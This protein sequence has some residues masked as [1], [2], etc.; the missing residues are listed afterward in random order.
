MKIIL[1]SLATLALTACGLSAHAGVVDLYGQPGNFY[2]DTFGSGGGTSYYAQSITADANNFA[3][4]RFTV[5]AA[6]SG[7][8]RMH[9]TTGLPAGLAGTGERP[10]ANNKLFSQTLTHTGGGIVNFDLNLNLG[11]TIGDVLFFVLDSTGQTLT[12][13]SVLATQYGGSDKYRGGEFIYS[14]TNVSLGSAVWDSRFSNG[15]DL[16]FRAQFNNV[17]A[18]PEPASLALVGIALVGAAAARRRRA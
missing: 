17:N 14:N 10:D 13:A 6:T 12:D 7:T 4:L 2:Q 3:S 1:K 11:V 16:V 9:V 5:D 8:F 15:E 18:V